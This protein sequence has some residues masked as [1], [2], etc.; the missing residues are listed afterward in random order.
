MAGRPNHPDDAARWPPRGHRNL[1][2]DPAVHRRVPKQS[3]HRALPFQDVPPKQYVVHDE[4][5]RPD[6]ELQI[7]FVLTT[8]C[9][10]FGNYSIRRRPN[11]PRYLTKPVEPHLRCVGH[12]DFDTIPS[13]RPQSKFPCQFRSCKAILRRQEGI[14]SEGERNSRGILDDHGSRQ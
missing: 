8:G 9:V 10:C 5:R 12:I 3:S 11:M 14:Q 2:V 13:L 6:C 4:C 1:Q 7:S